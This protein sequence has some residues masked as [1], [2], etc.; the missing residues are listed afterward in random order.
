MET[1]CCYQWGP[2]STAQ[3][4]TA[5]DPMAQDSAAHF[6]ILGDATA[7]FGFRVY[8]TAHFTAHVMEEALI[9]ELSDISPVYFTLFVHYRDEKQ[10]YL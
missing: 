7:H 1:T 5:Q 6:S 4:S 2:D 10:T 3:D 9:K 8:S